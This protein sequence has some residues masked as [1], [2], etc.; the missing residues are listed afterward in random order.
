[1][2]LG[3]V[4]AVN[5]HALPDLAIDPAKIGWERELSSCYLSSSSE[6]GFVGSTN[7][8]TAL[9]YRSARGV[10]AF[11]PVDTVGMCDLSNGLE[12]LFV[13]CEPDTWPHHVSY[14]VPAPT[15]LWGRIGQTA[16]PL[17]EREEGW[18]GWTVRKVTAAARKVTFSERS[19]L[20]QILTFL[21]AR[22][23]GRED[24]WLFC[25]NLP[26]KRNAVFSYINSWGHVL[27]EYSMKNWSAELPTVP[28]FH[29]P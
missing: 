16:L 3:L 25:N 22:L 5:S 18:L 8:F 14:Q 29:L 24:Y 11:E 4:V 1:M 2:L 13:P 9:V 6:G 23:E 20:D 21:D 17:P 28:S 15:T 12:Y 26:P 10:V 7:E 19:P 27:H